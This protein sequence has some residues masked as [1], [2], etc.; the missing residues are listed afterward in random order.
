MKHITVKVLREYKEYLAEEEKSVATINKYISDIRKLVDF[1]NGRKI[2]KRLMIAYKDYLRKEK[3]YKTSSINSYLVAANRLFEY[4]G[5]Y[6]CKVKTYKIQQKIFTPENRELTKEE[7]EKLVNAAKHL[8]KTRICLILQTLC[9]TG[10][11]VSELSAFTVRGV[12]RGVIDIYNKGKERQILLSK[13]LQRILLRYI[14]EKAIKS[15]PVFCTSM[16]KPVDRTSIWREMKQLCKVAEVEE[17]KVFPHNLRHLF[18][19][20]FY[21]LNRDIAKLADILGHSSINTTR[22]YMRTS[23]CEHRKQLE[24][25]QLVFGYETES[26]EIQHNDNYVDTKTKRVEKDCKM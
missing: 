22:I 1:A 21:E 6:E 13:E 5:W 20:T 15:G 18:A 14:N 23:G 4:L 19:K 8:K 7:Y 17:E 16:G 11:R 10:I 3:E 24:L 9:A 25:L 12:K 2:T 26:G